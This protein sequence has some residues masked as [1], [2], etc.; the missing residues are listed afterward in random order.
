MVGA[1][2]GGFAG[3]CT[4]ELMNRWMQLGAFQPFFRNHNDLK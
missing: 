3:D 1:D 4:E 2:V